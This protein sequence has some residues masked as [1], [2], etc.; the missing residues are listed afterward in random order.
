MP[1]CAAWTERA[2]ARLA[3]LRLASRFPDGLT[4]EIVTMGRA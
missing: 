1:L 4:F 3:D 2:F